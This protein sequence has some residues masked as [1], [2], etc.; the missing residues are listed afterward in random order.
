MTNAKIELSFILLSME[1]TSILSSAADDYFEKKKEME[2]SAN[3]SVSVKTEAES[4]LVYKIGINIH[5]YFFPVI[6]VIGLFGNL[7]SL[8][9]L[10][11][12]KNRKFPCYRTLTALSISDLVIISSGLYNWGIFVLDRM[13]ETHCKIWTYIFQASALCSALL[14]VFVTTHKYLAFLSP[15]KSHQWRS[16]ER[17]LKIIFVVSFLSLCYSIVHIFGT[18]LVDEKLCTGITKETSYDRTLSWI[19]LLLHAVLPVSFVIVMNSLIMK[20]LRES[21]KFG[22]STRRSSTAQM[23][24]DNQQLAGLVNPKGIIQVDFV[25]EPKNPLKHYDKRTASYHK[26]SAVLLIAVTC[27]FAVLTPPLYLYYI[28]ANFV[29]YKSSPVAY[30]LHTLGYYICL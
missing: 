29:D 6:A 24:I 3:L 25:K 12:S 8:L 15:F 20:A 9:I 16:P 26:Q 4:L 19:A 21:N 2:D 28:V 11:Q 13:T 14:V 27:T 23:K 5:L 10:L 17:T 18:N 7:V 30:A 22:Q 1:F